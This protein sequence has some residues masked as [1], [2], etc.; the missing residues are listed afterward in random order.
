[1][2]QLL[3][4]LALF[5][6]L[7]TYAQ[8]TKSKNASFNLREVAM[9]SIEPNNN[10]VLL[11][12][13]APNEAG[14]SAQVTSNNNQKWINFTSAIGENASKRNLSIR[15]DNGNVPSGVHLKVITSNY[16]GSGRGQLGSPTSTL[17]LNNSSQTLVSNIGGAY[18]GTGINNGYKLT[19]D[20]E[21][22]DYKL[23]DFDNSETLTISL[24]LTDF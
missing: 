23:L 18:T 21:V 7:L 8:V 3:I 16:I 11:N 9:L 17:T 15:I 4:I 14:E 1:M 20:L 22:Y 12:L 6:S 10:S 19:Y 24:T 2:K 13:N 5:S